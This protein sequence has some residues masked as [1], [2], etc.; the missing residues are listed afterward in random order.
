MS[1]YFLPEKNPGPEINADDYFVYRMTEY[2]NRLNAL[3][4][5]GSPIPDK[6]AIIKELDELCPYLGKEVLFSGSGIFSRQKE[7]G[8][9]V[10]SYD[11]RKGMV[12]ISRGI[13]IYRVK[14]ENEEKWK[15]FHQISLGKKNTTTA[16]THPVE[17]QF[18]CYLEA[19]SE[20][21]PSDSLKEIFNDPEKANEA[22][23]ESLSILRD[24]SLEIAKTVS[25]E[26][27]RQLPGASQQ[28]QIQA[29]VEVAETH[30]YLRNRDILISGSHCYS[31]FIKDGDL[32]QDCLDISRLI[33]VRGTCL[34]FESLGTGNQGIEGVHDVPHEDSGLC[35]VVDPC[36]ESRE[37][38]AIRQDRLLF[39]PLSNKDNSISIL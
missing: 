8:E 33:T 36:D 39:V 21:I 14:R 13:N 19:D 35:L 30:A 7:N 9:I 25:S 12:G 16:I 18:F 3:A 29:M 6:N 28:E 24:I 23:P 5:A 2:E 34:G 20:I 10:D 31:P 15:V 26:W 32:V 22:S 1:E 37:A 4:E 38:L 27:F 11:T 17:E